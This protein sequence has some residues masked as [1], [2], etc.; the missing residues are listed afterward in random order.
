MYES[1]KEIENTEGHES[2][3]KEGINKLVELNSEFSWPKIN[4]PSNISDAFKDEVFEIKCGVYNG[5]ISTVKSSLFSFNTED[6]LYHY[7]DR[8]KIWNAV[9]RIVYT[10]KSKLPVPILETMEERKSR[11]KYDSIDPYRIRSRVKEFSLCGEIGIVTSDGEQEEFLLRSSIY[12]KVKGLNIEGK[13]TLVAFSY[14]YKGQEFKYAEVIL[15]LEN[16]KILEEC[17]FN[18]D[19][20]NE[21]DSSK[22]LA[23]SFNRSLERY[24]IK[25]GLIMLDVVSISCGLYMFFGE[26]YIIAGSIGGF[27]IIP[28]IA[29]MFFPSPDRPCLE[30]INKL[31]A[32][33]QKNLEG[34]KSDMSDYLALL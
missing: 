34:I 15:D 4:T 6:Q 11:E 13:V 7:K 18:S 19:N 20:I 31:K 5:T 8:E 28:T 33:W 21:V 1:I 16:N 22:V 2:K 27:L 9:S 32:K 17:S 23:N 10:P 29:S 24:E 26:H 14:I 25:E 30:F 3:L 12:E